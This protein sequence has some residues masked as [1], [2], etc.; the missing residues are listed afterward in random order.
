MAHRQ[1]PSN[2]LGCLLV[3]GFMIVYAIGAFIYWVIQ[4][5]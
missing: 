1:E 2:V 3:I 4:Q 5:F